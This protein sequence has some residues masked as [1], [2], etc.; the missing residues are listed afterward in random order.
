MYLS[1]LEKDR[2]VQLEDKDVQIQ[3]EKGAY[4]ELDQVYSRQ[5]PDKG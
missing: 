2:G 1:Y 5:M 3:Q 4:H